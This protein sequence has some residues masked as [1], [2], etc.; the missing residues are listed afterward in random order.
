MEYINIASGGNAVE[1]GDT[2]NVSGN[3]G[4]GIVHHQLEEFLLVE[5]VLQDS[6]T[7]IEFI[8]IGGYAITF[9]T[10]NYHA[11]YNGQLSNAHGGL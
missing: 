2:N 5:Q 9:D 7:I 1:F 4:S 3:S 11:Q 10:L 8:N 6:V